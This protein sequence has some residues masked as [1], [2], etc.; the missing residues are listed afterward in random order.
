MYSKHN[1]SKLYFQANCN[2]SWQMECKEDFLC[3]Q[4]DHE[5]LVCEEVDHVILE[6]PPEKDWE[7]ICCLLLSFSILNCFSITFAGSPD[8]LICGNC[9]EMFSDLVDMMEHKRDYCKLRFTCK[10][11]ALN[12]ENDGSPCTDC[13]SVSQL[14]SSSQSSTVAASTTVTNHG[15]N[16]NNWNFL[17]PHVFRARG[18]CWRR[19][20]H[21]KKWLRNCAPPAPFVRS[22]S[23]KL[24]C[25]Y[26]Q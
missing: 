25:Y 19:K 5:C 21:L 23:D 14:P 20:V 24:T 1:P 11:D 10:C 2:F 9:R 12:E 17:P 18:D 26:F 7:I 16:T 4:W 3:A 22:S 15:N 13:T 8:I 6:R